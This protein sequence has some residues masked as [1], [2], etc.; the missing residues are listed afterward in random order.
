LEGQ[1]VPVLKGESADVR[2]E[3]IQG[4]GDDECGGAALVGLV[5]EEFHQLVASFGIE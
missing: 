2:G 1:E 5:E 3:L 4:V